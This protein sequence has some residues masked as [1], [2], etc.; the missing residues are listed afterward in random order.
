[1]RMVRVAKQVNKQTEVPKAVV[2]DPLLGRHSRT[3]SDVFT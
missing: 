3:L 1:M 2:A